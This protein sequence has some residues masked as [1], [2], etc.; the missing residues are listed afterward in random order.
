MLE[1]Y[2]HRD[3]LSATPE[4]VRGFLD[5][6]FETVI[7]RRATHDVAVVAARDIA[8]A[9]G[10]MVGVTFHIEQPRVTL[11]RLF[12]GDVLR[13]ALNFIEDRIEGVWPAIAYFTTPSHIMWSDVVMRPSDGQAVRIALARMEA[14]AAALHGGHLLPPPRA[15]H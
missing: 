15:P 14:D 10:G 2:T 13:L 5:G 8:V 9:G 11:T 7:A 12:S 1:R 6:Y 3:R 4:F